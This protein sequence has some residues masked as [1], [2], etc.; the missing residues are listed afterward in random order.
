L[1][2][3]KTG[4]RQVRM[5]LVGWARPR[6]WV[7]VIA[8]VIVVA[9][10][11]GLILSLYQAGMVEPLMDQANALPEGDARVAR[12]RELLQFQTDNLAKIW[13]TIVQAVGGAVL[14]LGAAATWRNVRVAQ[15]NLEET[16]R[17][18]AADREADEATLRVT[19]ERLDSDR[20]AQ[21]TNRFTQAIGQLGA[22]LKDGKPNLEVRLGG[23]YALE[24][25]ARNSSQD[26]GPIMEVLTAYVR[27]NA[28]WPPLSA[29]SQLESLKPRADIQAIL[30]VL[31]RRTPPTG[32]VVLLDLSS[33][34]LR[35]ADLATA[36]L[37][38]SNLADA[39]LDMAEL[40]DTQL[41][42]ADLRRAQ[43]IGANLWNAQLRFAQLQEADLRGASLGAADFTAARLTGTR[44]DGP[45][46]NAA[47]FEGADLTG[48]QLAGAFLPGIWLTSAQLRDADL[49]GA[50]L[51]HA[52]LTKAYLARA[53][54]QNA[55]LRFTDL[56]GATLVHA[57]LT[58]AVLDEANLE[59]AQMS[60]ANLNGAFLAR[61][62]LRMAD[63]LTHGQVASAYEQGKGALLPP[64]WPADWRD[65]FPKPSESAPAGPTPPEP[66][67]P[68]DSPTL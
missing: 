21:I 39:H 23:I 42:G 34:D 41:A 10:A 16:K 44:L 60:Q 3:V 15:E 5:A 53:N 46:W 22:E 40:H 45:I 50:D 59:A 4:A 48:V 64:G 8:M 11:L 32:L 49:Q 24:R 67:E 35:G 6:W 37:Q 19:Q 57:N 27:Q 9:L 7:V 28:P 66:N 14:A 56:K 26:Y 18:I 38:H 63:G 25:I 12:Q 30:T 52:H 1:G 17:K 33:T 58:G 36:D 65:H 68:N 29:P 51:S 31:R 43:L 61:A 55:R 2:S 20:E 54:L 13:T 62:D 47:T